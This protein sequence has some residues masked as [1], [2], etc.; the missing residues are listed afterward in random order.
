MLAFWPSHE[1]TLHDDSMGG[2]V[3]SVAGVC[4]ACGDAISASGVT[5]TTGTEQERWI[6]CPG[7]RRGTLHAYGGANSA[8]VVRIASRRALMQIFLGGVA[9]DDGSHARA[10]PSK[11]A[12]LRQAHSE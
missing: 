7:V 8:K 1:A 4:P 11:G 12:P 10:C 5:S 3:P 9:S 6:R 2:S